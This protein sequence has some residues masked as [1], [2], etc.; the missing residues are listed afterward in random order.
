[1]ANDIKNMSRR[2]ESRSFRKDYEIDREQQERVHNIG[3]KED[4]RALVQQV[5]KLKHDMNE[6]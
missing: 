1:M 6:I 4:I 2:K 5:S 3:L